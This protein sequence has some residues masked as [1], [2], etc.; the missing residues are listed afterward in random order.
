MVSVPECF[1]ESYAEARPKFCSAAAAS[2]GE[3]RS[4]LNPSGRG[5]TGEALYLDTARFGPRDAPNML[6]LIAGT[7]GVEGHCGSG[8]EIAWLRNGGP[9]KLPKDTGALLIHAINPHGFAWTRR[10]T[11]DNVDLNRNF[12]DHAAGAWPANPEY[13]RLHPVLLPECW[14]DAGRATMEAAFHAYIAEHGAFGLQTALSRGQYDHADGIFYGG[15]APTWSNRTFRAIAEGFCR[16]AAHI[17]FLD[18]HTG[19]GPYG[20]A[21][22][23]ARFTSGSPEERRLRAWFGEGLTSPEAGD[24]TSPPLTGLIADGLITG[25]PGADVVSVTVEYGTYPIRRILAA[26]LADNW[27]H[28]RGDVQS[29]L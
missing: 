5:P 1:S 18:F 29:D 28:A 4:W 10:V 24:S 13:G 12:V 8:A 14:D 19:L 16:Q 2:G 6:V 17:A 3:I 20:H 21:E 11:E 7:H 9:D 25:C 27:L 22:M 15:R 26:L 23:I